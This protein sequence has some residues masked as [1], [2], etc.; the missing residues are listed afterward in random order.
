[1]LF[2]GD[3]ELDEIENGG[4]NFPEKEEEIT[5][6]ATPLHWSRSIFACKKLINTQRLISI[7]YQAS[8][9]HLYDQYLVFDKLGGLFNIHLITGQVERRPSIRILNIRISLI[10]K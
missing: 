7:K 6:R 3:P 9:Q 10:L 8:K 4:E 2:T 5:Q 1:M